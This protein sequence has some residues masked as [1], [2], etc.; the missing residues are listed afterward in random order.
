M[1]TVMTC[2]GSVDLKGV[3]VGKLFNL[4]ANPSDFPDALARAARL[5]QM[6]AMEGKPQERKTMAIVMR[7]ASKTQGLGHNRPLKQSYNAGFWNGECVLS[8]GKADPHRAESTK[9]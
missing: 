2:Y 9:Y 4:A 3:I 6:D 1:A 5:G 7:V 8:G